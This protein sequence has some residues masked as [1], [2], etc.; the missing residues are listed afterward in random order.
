M[1]L[2]ELLDH[3]DAVGVRLRRSPEGGVI[4]AGHAQVLSDDLVSTM[5]AYKTELEWLVWARP[6]GHQWAE[7]S[8]C[9]APVLTKRGDQPCRMT[10][11]C[12]GR[13]VPPTRK[14]NP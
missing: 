8:R 5:R 10:P 4:A 11:G 6:M 14:A 13:H 12:E 2:L 3:L 7:C 9:G 1:T